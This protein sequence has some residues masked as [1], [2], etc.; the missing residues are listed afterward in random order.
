MKT[1]FSRE[2]LIDIC[3]HSIVPEKWWFNRDTKYSQSGVGTVW[4][5]LRAGCEFII[6]VRD[7]NS[8]KHQ[9]AVTD[10]KTIWIEILSKEFNWIENGG[11]PELKNL[12]DAETFYLPTPDRLKESKGKD[13]Y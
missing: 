2:E 8:K 9:R 6:L 5:L 3:E 13:W 4:A 11:D 7:P 12:K 10:S 1:D